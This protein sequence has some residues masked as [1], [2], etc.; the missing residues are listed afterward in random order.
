MACNLSATH[1][2]HTPGK[3]DESQLSWRQAMATHDSRKLGMVRGTIGPPV[4]SAAHSRKYSG[5]RAAGVIT[6]R[7]FTFLLA[8]L[9][10]RWIAPRRMQSASPGPTSICLAV[11]RPCQHS[12]NAIDG[13]LIVVVAMSRYRQTFAARDS[14]LKESGAV[15][16]KYL[17]V[18]CKVPWR[19]QSRIVNWRAPISANMVPHRI[20]ERVPAH[21]DDTDLL[22]CRLD[23]FLENRSQVEGPVP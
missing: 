12:L 13:L 15:A 16:C 4:D 10:K 18:T 19:R 5:R 1:L 14:E 22:K 6:Q 11:D 3:K 17:L 8:L 21:S 23:L 2:Y 20:T 9:S 7:V